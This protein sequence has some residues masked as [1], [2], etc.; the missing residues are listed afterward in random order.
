MT[1]PTFPLGKPTNRP[2]PAKPKLEPPKQVAPGIFEVDGKLETRIPV[3]SAAVIPLYRERNSRQHANADHLV[4]ADCARYGLS[5][6]DLDGVDLSE[7]RSAQGVKIQPPAYPSF[8]ERADIFIEWVP[9]AIAKLNAPASDYPVGT[10][11]TIQD[12]S[13]KKKLADGTTEIKPVG[14]VTRV[15]LPDG[16]WIESPI[17]QPEATAVPVMHFEGS[18]YVEAPET[19]SCKG[20]AFD[21]G[22]CAEQR[23]DA[24]EV[25]G[26]GCSSREVI[27]IKREPEKAPASCNPLASL[28]PEL[29]PLRID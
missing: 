27:Y 26:A 11:V 5:A 9:A 28:Y 6:K 24:Y 4:V 13:K 22:T 25:F 8:A 16:S 19:D 20:C 12:Y 21:T 3:N 7:Y 17:R 2:E 1:D 14:S 15:T 18:E 29:P 10:K 23:D